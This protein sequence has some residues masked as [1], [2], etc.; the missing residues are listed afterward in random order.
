MAAKIVND[1]RDRGD[2]YAAAAAA[3]SET[4]ELSWLTGWS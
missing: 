4:E 3:Q 1:G 2:S